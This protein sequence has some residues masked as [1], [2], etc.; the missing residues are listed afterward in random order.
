MKS[1]TTTNGKSIFDIRDQYRRICNEV[2]RR[3]YARRKAKIASGEITTKEQYEADRNK[4]DK[5]LDWLYETARK[6]IFELYPGHF[7]LY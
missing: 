4:E 6:M 2:I 7:P 5:F 1:K 3:E